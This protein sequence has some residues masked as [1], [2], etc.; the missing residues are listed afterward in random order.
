MPT[1]MVEI[2]CCNCYSVRKY[3]IDRGTP[4]SEATL[5]CPNCG[6]SPTDRDYTVLAV[7]GD[8]SKHT[9]EEPKGEKK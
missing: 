3:E 7:G 4:H 8:Y 9:R 2:S 5:N 1:Y 6:C